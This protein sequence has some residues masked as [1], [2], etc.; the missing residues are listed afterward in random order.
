[1]Y[2]TISGRVYAIHLLNDYSGS[3]LVLR[4]VIRN[5]KNN[6]YK[7]DIITSTPE[8]KGFLS[9][10][11]GVPTHEIKYR[12]SSNKL[13]TFLLYLK[14][15]F[16]LFILLMQKLKKDDTVYINTLLPFG[17]A[18]AAK[19]KRNK[20][21]YHIH[22]VSIRPRLFMKFLNVVA[23]FT[24]KEIVFVSNYTASQF[25]FKKPSIRIVHN[26]LPFEFTDIA[27]KHR[28][29]VPEGKFTVLMLSSLKA[30][31][32]IYE[33]LKLARQIPEI[34]FRLVLNSNREAI[35]KFRAETCPSSNVELYPATN[36][37]HP[38]YQAAHVVVNLSRPDQWIE[39]FG[40]TI[41]EAFA[42]GKPVICPP[43]GGPVEIVSH[44]VN[45]FHADSRDLKNLEKQLRTLFTSKELY[46][47]LAMNICSE[48]TNRNESKQYV[49]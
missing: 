29:K 31:K 12:W 1:M 30:Y 6:G 23:E 28:W 20:I 42:Y 25:H 10:I 38:H 46:H 47:H 26:R 39:T 15:Q 41:L 44:G 17:A 18:M 35:E 16:S 49:S 43:V 9:D 11:D 34:N 37:T 13:L 48:I 14:S 19:I 5:M 8:K 4:E 7:V 40:M 21:I 24:A 3:P 32:G 36:N 33:F 45:G 27:L 22:E 2:P